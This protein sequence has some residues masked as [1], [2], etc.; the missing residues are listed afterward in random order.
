MDL[1][2]YLNISSVYLW[3]DNLLKDKCF[4]CLR[5]SEHKVLMKLHKVYF[6]F[7]V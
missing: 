7:S 2:D 5:I 3:Y 4:T 6:V 1:D